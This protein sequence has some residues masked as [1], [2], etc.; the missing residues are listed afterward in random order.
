MTRSSGGIKLARN[1][2]SWRA[3]LVVIAIP[4]SAD[5]GDSHIHVISRLGA[6]TNLLSVGASVCFS[7]QQLPVFGFVN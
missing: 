3:V 2:S 4:E 6:S 1:N 7:E 5:V